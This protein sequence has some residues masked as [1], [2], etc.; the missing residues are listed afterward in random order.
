MV[1]FDPHTGIFTKMQGKYR[2]WSY[3]KWVIS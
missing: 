2:I 3:S 1:A